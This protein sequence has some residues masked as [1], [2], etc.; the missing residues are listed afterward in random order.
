MERKELKEFNY[1]VK[2]LKAI[3]DRESLKVEYVTGEACKELET[4]RFYT[5]ESGT[6]QSER[7]KLPW[8]EE[9]LIIGNH[10]VNVKCNSLW[11]NLAIVSGA[12]TG[13][14]TFLGDKKP[15]GYIGHI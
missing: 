7:S 15:V 2:Q 10:L 12:L 9:I 11:Y 1:K 3:F 6:Y 8:A 13:V 4:V 5:D 14:Y